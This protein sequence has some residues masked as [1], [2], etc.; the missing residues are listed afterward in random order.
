MFEG[1]S[2]MNPGVVLIF[3]GLHDDEDGVN[4]DAYTTQA[5]G[6]KPKDACPNLALVKAMEA[7]IAQ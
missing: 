2:F 5:P 1:F 3:L 7:E 4:D 6:A